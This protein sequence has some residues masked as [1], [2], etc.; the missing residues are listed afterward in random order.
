MYVKPHV[1]YAVPNK[2]SLT[3]QL[4]SLLTQEPALEGAL[5]GLSI[6]SA[7][8][9][10]ILYEHLGNARLKPASNLKLFT[11]AAALS[12]L[13]ED[14][15]FK[16]ELLT[17]GKVSFGM[18]QGNLYVKGKGDP[19]LLKSDLDNMVKKLKESGIKIIRGNVIA[20]DT[21]YDDVRYS[22]DLPWSDETTYYGAQV[23][24]LTISPNGD[25]DA[26]SV[27][28]GISPGEDLNSKAN[29]SLKPETNY[30]TVINETKTVSSEEKKRLVIERGHG[31]NT[32]KITGTIPINSKKVKEWIAVWDPTAYALHLFQQSLQEHGIK[33]LGDATKGKTPETAV[34]LHTHESIPLSE[35]IIPFMKFSNNGHA[36]TLIKE[37]GKVIKGE[38]SWEQGLEVLETEL[39]KLGVNTNTLVLRDGSGISHVNLVPANEISKLLYTIQKKEWFPTYLTSLPIAGHSNRIKGGTLRHRM[40]ETSAQERVKAKTGTLSTVSSLSGYVKTKSGETLIFSILLNNLAVEEKGK[41]IE[42]KIAELLANL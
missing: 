22:K 37:M 20:D 15:S 25:Y 21:W 40:K 24:A 6:R 17:D 7:A 28:V 10:E 42:N 14:Y 13:G 8:S 12:I 33:L 29:I 1:L 19:T 4:N 32:I 9:G 41:E 26:G 23:S 30:I 39:T 16:T 5:A 18:I 38:G 35:L 3:Y 34:L 31:T 2:H 36:E 11:A 27:I